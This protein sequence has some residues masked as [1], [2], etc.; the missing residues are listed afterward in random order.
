MLDL[1]DIPGKKCM[2]S[3]FSYILFTWNLHKA[4]A[5]CFLSVACGQEDTNK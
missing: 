1:V 3:L 4:D 2:E 5:V